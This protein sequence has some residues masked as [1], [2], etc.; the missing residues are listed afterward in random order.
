MRLTGTPA[1]PRSLEQRRGHRAAAGE[2]GAQRGWPFE[3]GV[4][5]PRERRRDE[6]DERHALRLERVQHAVLLEA[7]VHDGARRVD[8]RAHQDRQPADVRQR[9]R[10]QPALVGDRDPA[11]RPSRARSTGGCRRSARPARG[12]D[13]VPE[14]W[15]TAAVASS[16]CVS[17][18]GRLAGTGPSPSGCS[19]S[20]SAPVAICSRSAGARRRSTGT[21]TA[22]SS[23]QA[24]SACANS[25]PA[26]S[27]I[28]TRA[29]GPAPR[30]ISSP[31]SEARGVVQP[32]VGPVPP[33]CLQRRA[34]GLRR[35][36]ASE[37]CLDLHGAQ[38][39]SRAQGASAGSSP[40]PGRRP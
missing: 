28:A 1:A 19:T 23:R 8:R 15:I 21:A 24:C 12:A 4:E 31:R 33:G 39:R 40:W 14:V 18:P 38:A 22:P 10:A 2:R 9:Q 34:L 35:G 16:S 3:A 11:R 30:S 36:R 6:A 25:R 27:A 32:G 13:V 17:T 20:T 26:G 37:P 29:P 5:Q 7:L